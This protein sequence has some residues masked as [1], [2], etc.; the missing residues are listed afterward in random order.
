[1]N[2]IFIAPECLPFAKVTELADVVTK[3][4]KDIEKEGHNVKVLI[5][6]YGSI[7]PQLFHIERLPVD[8]KFRFN[9][10]NATAMVYKGIVPNSFVN[11]FFIDSQSYFSNSKEIY[12]GSPNGGE[13]L[14]R[15]KF[16]SQASLEVIS[17]LKLYP[18]VIHLFNSSTAHAVR[19][20]CSK[21]IEYTSL[22]QARIIFTL[23]STYGLKG[24]L[25]NITS[26]AIKH[27]DCI[28]S[29]SKA[30]AHELLSN[31]EGAFLGIQSSIDEDIYN[32]ESDSAITQTYS[33]NY[34]SIGKRK[35]KE[36]LLKEA[37]LEINHQIPLFGYIAR[38]KEEDG[39]DV[40]NSTIPQIGHLNIQLI[41]LNRGNQTI[42]QELTKTTSRYKNIKVLSAHEHDTI[43]K[44]YAGCDFFIS[45]NK[46]EPSGIS[47]L[48]AMKY[49]S[50]PI[51]YATGA[52]KD[53]GIDTYEDDER[54]NCFSFSNYKKDDLLDA[55]AK[56]IKYYKNREKWPK[57]VKQ[58]MTYD[59]N[60]FETAKKYINCYKSI[61]NV[62]Q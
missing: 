48:N 24:E 21:Q 30:Y 8:F 61:A 46:P 33:S 31:G 45:I 26:D 39:S 10:T 2:V 62:Y 42:E 20:L 18:D 28:T 52:I 53:I 34:F 37:G 7:D 35:C 56:A 27:S 57:L 11:V 59:L 40:L 49:G 12:L 22:N 41:I 16:F 29:V 54:G 38:L 32:P 58:C 43:K 3:L 47:A 51:V 23:Y 19:L 1:M 50:V 15:N 9:D 36:D 6:R 13:N 4:S 14:E 25:L 5:P 44:I 55:I 17:K 60:T